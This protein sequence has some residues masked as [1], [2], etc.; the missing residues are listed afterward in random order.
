MENKDTKQFLKSLTQGSSADTKS[1]L[2]IPGLDLVKKALKKTS[3]KQIVDVALFSAG[4]YVMFKF[5]KSVAETID[6]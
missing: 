4:I 6:N 1:K 2:A 5:G 3:K